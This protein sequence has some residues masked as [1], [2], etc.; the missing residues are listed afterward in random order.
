MA[1]T[2]MG[3]SKQPDDVVLKTSLM[4]Y[5]P[6][7]G[8]QD[9][10][11]PQNNTVQQ[12][13]RSWMNTVTPA[14]IEAKFG[15]GPDGIGNVLWIELG[16]EVETQE[17][18]GRGVANGGH[19]PQGVLDS[20]RASPCICPDEVSQVLRVK[21]SKLGQGLCGQDIKQMLLRLE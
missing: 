12:V 6:Q 4:L 8:R 11:G 3:I 19:G 9:R 10:A 1:T 17:R 2:N 7:D 14:R 16:H 18:L 13:M 21:A 20:L 15:K 5:T